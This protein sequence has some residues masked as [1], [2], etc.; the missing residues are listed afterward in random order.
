MLSAQRKDKPT[1]IVILD[2]SMTSHML[3][4]NLQQKKRKY[5]LRKQI[6]WKDNTK[7]MRRGKVAWR[8]QYQGDEHSSRQSTNRGTEI[9]GDTGSLEWKSSRMKFQPQY[10][11]SFLGIT[12]IRWNLR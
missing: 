12:I 7:E 10:Q 3:N 9:Q 2:L 6:R 11:P 5:K 1:S 4:K 8:G